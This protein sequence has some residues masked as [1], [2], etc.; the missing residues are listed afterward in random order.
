[1][2]KQVVPLHL[3]NGCEVWFE[4]NEDIKML[5]KNIDC[6]RFENLIRAAHNKKKVSIVNKTIFQEAYYSAL[7]EGINITEHEARELIERRQIKNDSCAR[8]ILNSYSAVNFI[9]SNSNRYLDENTIVQLH[10]IVS[11]GSMPYGSGRRTNQDTFAELMDFYNHYE[12]NP[13]IKSCIIYYYVVHSNIF[14]DCNSWLGRLLSVMYLLKNDYKFG[15]FCSPAKA[16]LQNA[17]ELNIDFSN[18]SGELT[19]FIEA[20]LKVYYIAAVE[21]SNKLKSEYGL[22]AISKAFREKLDGYSR[23]QIK[24]INRIATG[25][26][27]SIT[28]SEYQK[29]TGLNYRNARMELEELE[30]HGLF[31]KIKSGNKFVFILNDFDETGNRTIS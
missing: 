20:M 18:D 9:I 11:M 26:I 25:K 23:F 5:T 2:E 7:L 3:Q 4:V 28:I 17:A 21:A 31:K 22:K 10:R 29:I 13:L 12:Y 6:I 14:S 19:S 8:Q 1:M 15:K 27:E 24:T 16:I 30:E